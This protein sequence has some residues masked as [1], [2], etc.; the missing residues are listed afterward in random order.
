MKITIIYDNE[1]SKEGL[2]REVKFMPIYSYKCQECKEV[3][4]IFL[5]SLNSKVRCPNCGSENL[6]KLF[7]SSFIIG[8]KMRESGKTCCGRTERCDTPPCSTGDVCRRR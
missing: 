5:P 4:D 1:V 2:V 8:S 6:E 7:A 3:V